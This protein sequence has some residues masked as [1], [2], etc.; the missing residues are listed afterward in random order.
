MKFKRTSRQQEI[1]G[2]QP[3]R[4]RSVQANTTSQGDTEVNQNGYV[5]NDDGG[6]RGTP[7][8]TASTFEYLPTN[9]NQKATTWWDDETATYTSS[10]RTSHYQNTELT[11]NADGSITG[12]RQHI[13]KVQEDP[14]DVCRIPNTRSTPTKYY[15]TSQLGAIGTQTRIDTLKNNPVDNTFASIDTDRSGNTYTN[16]PL[17]ATTTGSGDSTAM[18]VSGNNRQHARR[19]NKP[20]TQNKYHYSGAPQQASINNNKPQQL[21]RTTTPVRQNSYASYY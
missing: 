2:Q 17:T 8:C 15:P 7:T 18:D 19:N 9:Y 16:T 14:V 5:L 3:R 11:Q 12:N 20:N 10:D 13:L 4:M 21:H 6:Y 1:H